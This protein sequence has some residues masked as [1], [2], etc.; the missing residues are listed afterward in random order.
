MTKKTALY[1]LASGLVADNSVVKGFMPKELDEFVTAISAAGFPS[2]K[3]FVVASAAGFFTPD[4]MISLIKANDDNYKLIAEQLEVPVSDTDV[5]AIRRV[6]GILTSLKP[7][8]PLY[9]FAQVPDG[10]S[11]A[12]DL[13]ILKTAVRRKRIN[14][15]GDGSAYAM[16]RPQ[17]Q[18]IW[19]LASKLWLKDLGVS[20]ESI[21][22]V[23]ADGYRRRADVYYDRVVIG[24]Q[25]F[26][27]YELEQLA[28]HL[29]WAFPGAE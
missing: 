10:W 26:R 28:V 27:R 23:S 24:C 22:D 20:H 4:N 9:P 16:T 7:K 1:V 14:S 18:R 15:N 12:D 13:S 3:L 29:G 19:G 17:L 2:K 11:I 6:E 25:T 5:D 21:R 8:A